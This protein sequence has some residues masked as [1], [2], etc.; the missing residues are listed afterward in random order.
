M[1]L[2]LHQRHRKKK[3]YPESRQC[4]AAAAGKHKLRCITGDFSASMPSRPVVNANTAAFQGRRSDTVNDG[5]LSPL[6]ELLLRGGIRQMDGQTGGQRATPRNGWNID[7][8]YGPVRKGGMT[9]SSGTV[10]LNLQ[11]W[12]HPDRQVQSNTELCVAASEWSEWA[13]NHGNNDTNN[14]HCQGNIC[15]RS[16]SCMERSHWQHRFPGTSLTQRAVR[17]QRKQWRRSRTNSQLPLPD[18]VVFVNLLILKAY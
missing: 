3:S 5:S 11:R 6:L 7:E 15:R 17:V 14:V 1:V 4:A 12:Q 10:S 16:G 9:Y 8:H 18:P 2:I 13:G